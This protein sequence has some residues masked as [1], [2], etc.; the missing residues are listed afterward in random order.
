MKFY[1]KSDILEKIIDELKA[2]KKYCSDNCKAMTFESIIQII[3]K[4]KE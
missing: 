3:E 1:I 4:Y 2:Y